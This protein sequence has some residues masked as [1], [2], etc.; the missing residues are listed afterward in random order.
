MSALAAW[1]FS[2]ADWD[3]LVIAIKRDDSRTKSRDTFH[4]SIQK[5]S[6]ADSRVPVS[7]QNI[8]A[9]FNAVF[10]ELFDGM[11]PDK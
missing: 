9:K 3:E 2:D 4:Y 1:D 8:P 10:K 7:I 5:D 11:K 6:D